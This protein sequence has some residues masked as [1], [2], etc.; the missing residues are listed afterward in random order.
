VS[1]FVLVHGAFSGGWYWQPLVPEL[2]ARGHTVEAIDLPGHGEDRTPP[3]QV[4]LD[5]YGEAVAE[6]LRAGEPAVLVGHSM[7]GMVVTQAAAKARDRVDRLIY[8]TAFLPRDG[9]SLQMLASYPESD[10]AVQRNLVVEPP[11]GW[12]TP[13]GAAEALYSR[14]S[15]EQIAWAVPLGQ[16][17]PLAPLS[18]PV[19]LAGGIDEIDRYY[20][21][22]TED[23]AISI[24]L[25]RRMIAD[26][27]CKEVA[28]IVADHS[29]FLSATVELAGVLDRLARA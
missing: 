26:S 21:C 1:R 18:D 15:A 9:Q 28:E 24:A 29:P 19:Q 7:G 27:P 17:Q 2:E 13:E 10:D 3:E 25:Q 11:V 23:N 16:P 5:A 12:L 22:C 8:L 4:T 14:C 20:V 6:V